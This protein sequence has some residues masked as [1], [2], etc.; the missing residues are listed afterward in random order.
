MTMEIRAAAAALALAGMLTA[1][2]E[3]SRPDQGSSIATGDTAPAAPAPVP[4]KVGEIKLNAAE[5][6]RYDPELDVWFVSSFGEG[7]VSPLGKDN[8]GSIGRYKGDASPDSVKFI[9]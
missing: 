2:G 7:E 5:A 6:A 8:N 3:G 9:A 4:R 1:C